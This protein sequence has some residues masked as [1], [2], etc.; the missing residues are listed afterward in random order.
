MYLIC[1]VKVDCQI[2]MKFP[3]NE[4]N[5]GGLLF[6][7]MKIKYLDITLNLSDAGSIKFHRWRNVSDRHIYFLR[8]NLCRLN[9]TDIIYSQEP[10]ETHNISIIQK[11]PFC[12]FPVNLNLTHHR[13]IMFFFHSPKIMFAR[14]SRTVHQWNVV[15]CILWSLDFFSQ[16][17]F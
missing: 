9:C 5:L 7:T 11:R 17:N 2:V 10:I 14:W 1:K 13:Q 8:S 15:S 12:A 6:F 16:H 4:Y 3:V